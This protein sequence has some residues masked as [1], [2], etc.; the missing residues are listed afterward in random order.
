MGLDKINEQIFKK[1]SL[2]TSILVLFITVLN[3]MF[4][5]KVKL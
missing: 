2:I 3:A 1:A 5:S 4:P